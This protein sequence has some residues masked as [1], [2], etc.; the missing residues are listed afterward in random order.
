MNAIVLR[1]SFKLHIEI[2]RCKDDKYLDRKQIVNLN[3]RQARIILQRG[4]GY[5]PIIMIYNEY[6]TRYKFI[7][8]LREETSSQ[9]ANCNRRNVFIK[10]L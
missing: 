4:V 6:Q 1:S 7:L 5:N 3:I 9:P 10:H 8:L 2:R